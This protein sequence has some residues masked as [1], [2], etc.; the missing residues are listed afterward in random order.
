[1][2]GSNKFKDWASAH[3]VR[4][5]FKWSIKVPHRDLVDFIHGTLVGLMLGFVI[6][7]FVLR[8]I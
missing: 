7:L 5:P 1:M 2:A 8:F 6:G 4:L 3:T